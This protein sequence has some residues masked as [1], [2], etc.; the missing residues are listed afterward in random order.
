[1]QGDSVDLGGYFYPD[2]K[3]VIEAMRPSRTFNN[4]LFRFG[5]G[6]L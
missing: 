2:E 4:I 6:K 3:K 1:M 5:G